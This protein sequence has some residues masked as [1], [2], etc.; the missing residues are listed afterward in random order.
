MKRKQNPTYKINGSIWKWEVFRVPYETLIVMVSAREKISLPLGGFPNGVIQKILESIPFPEWRSVSVG[1]SVFSFLERIHFSIS[2]LGEGRLCRADGVGGN[3]RCWRLHN[4]SYSLLL[5]IHLFSSSALKESTSFCRLALW[6]NPPENL[7][8]CFLNIS[9]VQDM[10]SESEE[11]D[12][13]FYTQCC[14][15]SYIAW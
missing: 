10:T 1:G 14:A 8:G 12:E 15:V 3:S 2:W 13:P 4:E 9:K 6:T 11:E 7:G 5:G